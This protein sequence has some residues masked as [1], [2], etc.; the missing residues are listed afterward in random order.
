MLPFRVIS[1]DFSLTG[2]VSIISAEQTSNCLTKN[3]SRCSCKQKSSCF[4]KQNLQCCLSRTRCVSRRSKVSQWRSLRSG[5]P[6][7][8]ALGPTLFLIIVNNLPDQLKKETATFAEDTTVL[9]FC[10]NPIITSKNL[11]DDLSTAPRWV[12]DWG[13]Y[14]RRG[15]KNSKWG[16]VRRGVKNSKC[17]NALKSQDVLATVDFANDRSLYL[18]RQIQFIPPVVCVILAVLRFPHVLGLGAYN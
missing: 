17:V 9:S 18:Y 6:R 10:K 1:G 4:C 5:I 11:S 7:Q 14:K 16:T 3:K 8:T 2:I 13:M 15:V 12:T